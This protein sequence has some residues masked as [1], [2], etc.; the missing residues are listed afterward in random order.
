[1]MIWLFL[2]TDLTEKFIYKYIKTYN[3]S[4][5]EVVNFIR[6]GKVEVISYYVQEF[7]NISHQKE[8]YHYAELIKDDVSN[9][10]PNKNKDNNPKINVSYVGCGSVSQRWQWGNDNGGPACTGANRCWGTILNGIIFP[11]WMTHYI[12]LL[13][14]LLDIQMSF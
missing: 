9:N 13:L 14:M 7:F 4:Y 3:V 12:H 2:Y 10:K 1:M 11:I 8:A 5:D 6:D